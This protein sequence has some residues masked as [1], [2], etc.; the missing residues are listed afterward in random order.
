MKKIC[1][2]ILLGFGFMF[3]ISSCATT[4]ITRMITQN[5]KISIEKKNVMDAITYV[6]SNNG[7]DV[8]MMNENYGLVNTNYRKV[9]SGTDTALSVL[10][11]IAAASSRTA[12]SYST[13]ARE[14]MLSFQI[15]D[16]GY[17]VVPKVKRTSNTTSAFS[18][19]SQDNVEYPTE[20]SAEGKLTN[21]IISEINNL[22]RIDDNYVWTEKEIS[23]SEQN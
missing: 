13:F 7:F 1:I 16:N 23:I 14:M 17:T 3:F 18:T 12:T 19:S 9:V 11:I 20:D 10:S 6:L 5:T 2:S 8:A 22:L 4:I 21:K 15:N